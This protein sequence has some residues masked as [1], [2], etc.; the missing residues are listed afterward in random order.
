M[1]EFNASEIGRVDFNFEYNFKLYNFD[2]I[3]I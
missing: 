1:A 3:N 2:R